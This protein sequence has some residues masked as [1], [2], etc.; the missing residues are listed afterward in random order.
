M[1]L[2]LF[3]CAGLKK[4]NFRLPSLDFLDGVLVL[5]KKKAFSTNRA[6]LIVTV[7]DLVVTSQQISEQKEPLRMILANG[8]LQSGGCTILL[9]INFQYVS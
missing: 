9:T 8:I 4:T 5:L 6:K 7:S 3:L 2:A 1:R